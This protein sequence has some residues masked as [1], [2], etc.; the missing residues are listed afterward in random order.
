MVTC[1]DFVVETN[2]LF[3]QTTEPAWFE[4]KVTML[5]KRTTTV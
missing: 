2:L 3:F 1:I 4:A 5:F